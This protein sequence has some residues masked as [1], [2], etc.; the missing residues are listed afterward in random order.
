MAA[1]AAAAYRGVELFLEPHVGKEASGLAQQLTAGGI[2]PCG[3][4]VALHTCDLAE[5]ALTDEDLA[6]SISGL[7]ARDTTVLAT[8]EQSVPGA[9]LL[10]AVEGELG[11]SGSASVFAGETWA[12]SRDLAW[13]LISQAIQVQ[14]SGRRVMVDPGARSALLEEIGSRFA[15]TW[16]WRMQRVMTAQIVDVRTQSCAASTY[17]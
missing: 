2:D 16:K 13:Q 11:R 7:N 6:R 9:Q 15:T 14:Q 8:L 1:A 3:A 10:A 4:Q 5:Q 17:S 12:E